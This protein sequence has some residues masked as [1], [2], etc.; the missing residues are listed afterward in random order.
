MNPTHL[1]WTKIPCEAAACPEIAV[2]D[3]RVYLRDS[4]RPEQVTWFT[5]AAWERLRAAIVGGFG[6]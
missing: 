1:T 3:N 2:T 4:D 6:A 5:P